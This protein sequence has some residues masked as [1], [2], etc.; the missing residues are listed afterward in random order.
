MRTYLILSALFAAAFLSPT[1]PATE[2]V[3]GLDEDVVEKGTLV[4]R[5]FVQRTEVAAGEPLGVV[6]EIR[7]GTDGVLLLPPG[8]DSVRETRA[9]EGVQ[10]AE[11]AAETVGDPGDPTQLWLEIASEVDEVAGESAHW[12]DFVHLR[13]RAPDK[14]ELAPGEVAFLAT[15]VRP[16]M[17]LP[18]DCTLTAKVGL[19]ERTL[20]EAGP[21]TVRCRATP[22]EE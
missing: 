20:A 7:N 22:A 2:R 10:V 18:G 1:G 3:P 6:L 19:G 13:R 9:P 12:I 11:L 15:A 5:M 17:F 4:V 16:S 21:V 14:D 8:G